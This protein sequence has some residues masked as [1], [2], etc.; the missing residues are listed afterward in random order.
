MVE[1]TPQQVDILERLVDAGFRPIAIPPYEK[2]LCV[3]RGECAAVL[4]PVSGGGLRL[5]APPTY[6][7]GGNLS[8]RLRRGERDLFVWKKTE[9][10]ATPERLATLDS[11]RRALMEILDAPQTP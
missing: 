9:L 8:V 2:A 10:A 5:L 6:M 11:F 3:H 1:L 4:S 7:M